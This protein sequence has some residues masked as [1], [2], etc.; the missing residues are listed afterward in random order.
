[1]GFIL[2]L[3][4]NLLFPFLF[5]LY[6]PFII[7]SSKISIKE[8]LISLKERLNINTIN[9]TKPLWFHASSIGEVKAISDIVKKS[10]EKNKNVLITT[11]T[12]TGK[13]E[14]LKLTDNVLIIPIDF[15]P[16]IKK[17]INKVNPQELIITETELW[18][19]LIK[20]SSKKT[21]VYIIN[22]R[23]SDKTIKKYKIIKP[24]IKFILKDI[25]KIL[26]QSEKDLEKFLLFLNKEKVENCG[27]IKY[28]LIN[29]NPEH[30]QEI[31]NAI[32]KLN[33]KEKKIITFGSTHF[34]EEKIIIKAINLILKEKKEIKFIIVPRHINRIYQIEKLFQEENMP[35]IKW[36]EINKSKKIENYDILIIDT[37]GLLIS[38]YSI[39]DICFI[40]GTL[41]NTGGHNLL[42][43]A[44]FSKPILFGPNYKNA[45]EAG[46]RLIEYRGGFI[47]KDE[48]ELKARINF[49]FS[50]QKYLKE[51][52]ENSFKALKSLQGATDKIK[53]YLNI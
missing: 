29:E 14:A 2:Y 43:P 44:Q 35:F 38:F 8:S 6:L 30:I 21:K 39:S 19:N 10:K 41:D 40:G 34:E 18:P 22:A 25:E 20:I 28:D 45:R 11:S 24:L 15:Y 50:S 51:A 48:Y 4:Y 13:K 17:F 9:I 3:T 36:S 33:W 31:K 52:G 5:I 26:T 27:N 49:L 46:D 16:L 37:I 12:L 53:K 32:E 42:E 7:F 47:V 23:I 1:M